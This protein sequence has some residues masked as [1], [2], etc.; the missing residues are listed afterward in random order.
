MKKILLLLAF[1]FTT[2][3][4]ALDIEPPKEA[5]E[6]KEVSK[7]KE[8]LQAFVTEWNQGEE[9]VY[10][11]L[12]TTNQELQDGVTKYLGQMHMN[13]W[14][15]SVK[16]TEKDTYEVKTSI[17]A[18]GYEKGWNFHVSGTT[19]TFTF[20]KREG[21]YVLISSNLFAKVGIKPILKIVGIVFIILGIIFLSILLLVLFFIRRNKR[22]NAH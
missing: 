13:A 15:K 9:T 7:V 21:K 8:T 11:Y 6:A 2:N 10:S 22:I 14:V 19:V 1:F 5:K 17:T 20:Q 12:D 16:E 18:E 4:M 3:V